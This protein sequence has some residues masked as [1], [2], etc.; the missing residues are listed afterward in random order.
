MMFLR[1]L[2]LGSNLSKS[3]ID[4]WNEHTLLAKYRGKFHLQYSFVFYKQ[5]SHQQSYW[6]M[7]FYFMYIKYK[8]RQRPTFSRHHVGSKLIISIVSFI[9]FTAS[10]YLSTHMNLKQHNIYKSIILWHKRCYSSSSNATVA[11]RTVK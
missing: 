9:V 2:F 6:S 10:H 11:T 4:D 3:R 5:N 7:R 8:Y 1:F